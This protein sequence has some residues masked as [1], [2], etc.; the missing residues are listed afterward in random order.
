MLYIKTNAATAVS[1]YCTWHIGDPV[2]KVGR[3]VEF[4]ADGDELELFLSAMKSRLVSNFSFGYSSIC[5][6]CGFVHPCL[7]SDACFEKHT[8]AKSGAD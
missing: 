8:E 2:P 6:I 5:L 4:Q 3:V 7:S 1:P